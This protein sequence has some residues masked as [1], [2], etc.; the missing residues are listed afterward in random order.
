MSKGLGKVQRKILEYFNEVKGHI[1]VYE[2]APT[3][4]ALTSY[5]FDVDFPNPS[6]INSVRRAVRN[7][8]DYKDLL[9][10]W[11]HPNKGSRKIDYDSDLWGSTW[12]VRVCH[13]DSYEYVQSQKEKYDAFSQNE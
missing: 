13:A 11:K 5:V 2:L 8:R 3:I 6:Q 7:L 1:D 4:S 9:R 12:D 10:T